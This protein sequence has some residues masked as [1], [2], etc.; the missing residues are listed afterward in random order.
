M[1]R[2][3]AT[4]SILVMRPLAAVLS[5][6]PGDDSSQVSSAVVMRV[7]RM[8]MSGSASTI[9]TMSKAAR[10]SAS[11]ASTARITTTFMLVTSS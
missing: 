9:S 10:S 4:C 8:L 11:V 3:S 5:M 7:G 1:R 2:A 6:T